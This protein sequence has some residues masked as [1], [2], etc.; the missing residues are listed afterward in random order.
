MK[1]IIFRADA[2]KKV[3]SGDLISL[4]HLSEYFDRRAWEIIFM[5][6][7]YNETRGILRNHGVKN[8]IFIRRNATFQEEIAQ[9]NKVVRGSN[10]DAI[11]LEIT[12][13][14]I[15]DYKHVAGN[16]VKACIAFDKNISAD[17]SLVVNWEP[18]AEMMYDRK[19]FPKT[20]FLLG[21][22]FVI[23]PKDF[24]FKL[25]DQ[26]VVKPQTRKVLVTMGG[27]DDLDFT[28]KLARVFLDNDNKRLGIKFIFVVGAN[29]KHK[30]RLEKELRYREGDFEVLQGVKNMFRQ[31]INCDIAVASGGLTL[32]ELIASRIPTLAIAT[33]A[34]QIPR[35]RYFHRRGL[36]RYLG[37]RKFTKAR[38]MKNLNFRVRQN[39]RID[40]KP[41]AIK[42]VFDE[43][44]R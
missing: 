22:E 34:H 36:I 41:A 10:I 8:V 26:R 42:G 2:Y 20:R 15:S 44:L 6:R 11:L 5:T 25:I 3:G 17:L 21:P 9:I 18:A 24:D 35:C 12:E 38:L 27:A 14:K 7:D 43:L 30:D 13:R 4:I 40:F 37:F 23:L 32:Y 39:R 33:Y 16:V 29:Y 19:G 31:F 28:R 1:R